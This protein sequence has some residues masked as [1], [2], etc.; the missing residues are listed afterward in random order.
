MYI[1]VL[2]FIICSAVMLAGQG[3]YNYGLCFGATWICLILYTVA[4]FVIYVFLVE[5]IHVVRA[6]FVRRSRDW[7]YLSC[8]VLMSVSFLAVAINAYL[9]P[10]I[11]MEADV[12]R[13]HMGI[14]GKASIPF[15][16]VD[17]VVDVALTGVFVYLLRPAVKMHGL[18]KMN[19]VFKVP[20]S[21]ML[22]VAKELHDTTVRKNIR[23]LLWKSL[24][25]SLLI[26]I[27]TVAN[28]IQFYVMHGRELALVCL[29]LC[30]IDG[31]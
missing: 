12:G 26:M 24:I 4:K 1:A 27:P 16:S 11:T 22:G 18:N 25:G 21:Q 23:T 19:H 31:K 10:I 17:I 3:L 15:M 9:S 13:C 2:S 7:L 5:R 8:L 20:K 30:T 6:P 14:P 28:M 29:A